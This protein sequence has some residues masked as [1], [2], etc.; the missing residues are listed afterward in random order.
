ME[1]PT[2]TQGL[3]VGLGSSRRQ[4]AW[5]EHRLLQCLGACGTL[6]GGAA[7]PAGCQLGACAT[8]SGVWHAESSMYSLQATRYCVLSHSEVCRGALSSVPGILT[9]TFMAR[10]QWHRP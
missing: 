1:G 4:L 8:L 10:G 3:R 2:T 9:W 5:A 6:K 7:V